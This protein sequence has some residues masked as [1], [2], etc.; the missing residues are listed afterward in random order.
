MQ[1]QGQHDTESHQ[2]LSKPAPQQLISAQTSEDEDV[3][4][5]TKE[6]EKRSNTSSKYD[7]VRNTYMAAE[8]IN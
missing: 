7:T 5:V 3:S 2:L 6:A 8:G 1:P 4:F